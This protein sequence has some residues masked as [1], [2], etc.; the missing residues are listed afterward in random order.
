MSTETQTA[1]E[2]SQEDID[3]FGNDSARS[4]VEDLS[5]DDS[6][7]SDLDNALRSDKIPR[8]HIR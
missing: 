4:S 7:I 2:L 3:K 5:E 1:Y 8:N 6:Q